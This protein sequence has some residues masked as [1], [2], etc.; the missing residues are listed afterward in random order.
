[1]PTNMYDYLADNF[2]KE[3]AEKLSAHISRICLVSKNRNKALKYFFCKTARIGPKVRAI[4]VSVIEK[5]FLEHKK[6][7]DKILLLI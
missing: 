2:K 5:D 4:L 7:L 6:L 3:I 1:M